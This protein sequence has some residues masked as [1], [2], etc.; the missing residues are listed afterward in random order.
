MRQ[1]DGQREGLVCEWLA[2]MS[3]VTDEAPMECLHTLRSLLCPL[4]SSSN[5]RRGAIDLGARGFWLSSTWTSTSHVSLES[6]LSTGRSGQAIPAGP[7]VFLV[8]SAIVRYQFECRRGWSGRI[9]W[10]VVR[11]SSS[12]YMDKENRRTSSSK[13]ADQ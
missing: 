7:G 4:L 10:V 8:S 6:D 3:Q 13:C 11:S 1:D 2:L 9:W 5:S 12:M